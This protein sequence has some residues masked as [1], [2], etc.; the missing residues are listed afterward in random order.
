MKKAPQTNIPTPDSFQV[1]EGWTRSPNRNTS[2]YALEVAY[3]RHA[4]RGVYLNDGHGNGYFAPGWDGRRLARNMRWVQ[5]IVTAIAVASVLFFTGWAVLDYRSNVEYYRLADVG[6]T[7]EAAVGAVEVEHRYSSSKR[8]HRYLTRTT[9]EIRYLLD[10][11]VYSGVITERT[12]DSRDYPEPEWVTGESVLL[13]TDPGD[14]ETFVVY[15]AYLEDRGNPVTGG[16]IFLIVMG[17]VISS[18]FVLIAL[19]ARSS[20]RKAEAL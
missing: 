18:L 12:T 13:Y 9:A 3:G 8:S 16:L 14:P 4:W 5:R 11:Q 6:V 10:G 15:D 17:V 2:R 7:A 19:V 20:R 1:P